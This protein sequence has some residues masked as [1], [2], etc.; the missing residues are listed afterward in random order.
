MHSSL[1]GHVLQGHVCVTAA[2]KATPQWRQ[3]SAACCHLHVTDGSAV[4]RQG[5][6]RGPLASWGVRALWR[7][8]PPEGVGT[9]G[10]GR[11]QARGKQQRMK[12]IRAGRLV[13]GASCCED[14]SRR[15]AAPSAPAFLGPQHP[16]DTPG[17]AP[18]SWILPTMCPQESLS[19]AKPNVGLTMALPA[20]TKGAAEEG[21]LP[22]HGGLGPRGVPMTT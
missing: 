17:S 9:G 13:W 2:G 18:H 8:L 10:G 3:M 12:G 5:L 7:H 11:R 15:L 4:S 19:R 22:C 6:A 20:Y 14:N 16:P 21:P 1:S